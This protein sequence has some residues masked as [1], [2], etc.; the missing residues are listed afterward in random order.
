MPLY[1]S[2]VHG[3]VEGR[4]N[5]ASATTTPLAPADA[6]R[7]ATDTSAPGVGAF[8]SSPPQ[9]LT[10]SAAAHLASA[11]G[12]GTRRLGRTGIFGMGRFEGVDGPPLAR[13]STTQDIC[14]WALPEAGSRSRD[15]ARAAR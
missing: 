15:G 4:G 9:P 13:R 1:S 11:I 5:G 14:Q 12:R 3:V 2:I 10:A 7:A 6:A 8:E